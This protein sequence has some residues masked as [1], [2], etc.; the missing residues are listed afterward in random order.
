MNSPI[1]EE[2]LQEADELQ[3]EIETLRTRIRAVEAERD[4]LEALVKSSPVGVMV[5]DAATRTF[6]SVNKEAERILGMSPEPGSSLVRYH[7]LTIYRRTDGKLYESHERPLSRALDRGDIVRAEEILLNRADGRTVTVLVN[8]T[9]IYSD[10][11]QIVSAVAV[12]QDM[13]PLEE[14]ERMRNEFL[15]TVSHELRTPLTVIKGSTATVLSASTPF[16][17][18]ETRRF[19]QTIDR[20]ADLLNDLVSN[21]LDVTKIEAGALLFTPKPTDMADLINEAAGA[22][23]RSGAGNHVEV[24]LPP[25]LP[26]VRADSQRATQ[27]LNNLL[28]NASKYSP[29][30]SKI[31]ITASLNESHVAVSVTDEGRGL[32]PDQMGNLFKNFSRL[33]ARDGEENVEGHGLGLSICK[34]IVE[35]HGGRIWAE[36]D[37]EGRGARFTFTIPTSSS[38]EDDPAQSSIPAGKMTT[39][40]DRVRILSVDADPQILRHIRNTLSDAG[41]RPVVTSNPMEMLHLLE[42]ERPHLVLLDMALPGTDGFALI[43]RIR[44]LSDVPIIFLSG[45]GGSGDTVRAFDMGA[46]DYII[47]PF[48]PPELIARID[49][50]LRKQARLDARGKRKPYRLPDLT[51]NYSDRLV[52]VA[53]REV[54]LTATEYKLLF[55]LSISAGRVL[56]HEQLLHRVWGPEY[57]DEGHLVRVVVANLRHKLGDDAKNPKFIFTEPR[58]GYRMAAPYTNLA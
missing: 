42:T 50:A 9:P 24:D 4:R 36:S 29:A 5:V 28:S 14:M 57:S 34:G 35:A 41:Y 12:I 52:K 21:L 8:A 55:Q 15:A 56:T 40:G 20:Q 3:R 33:D 54:R 13:T 31:E 37:G 7:E 6:A 27:V 46:S 58:V 43:E 45:S 47:K 39:T 26:P 2:L 30:S 53:D 38:A 32:P 11:G 23:V 48:S 10:D 19:F 1:L 18:D 49:A 25:Q 44:E 17:P 22:F 16:P 51:I